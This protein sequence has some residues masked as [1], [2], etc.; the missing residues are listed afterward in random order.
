MSDRRL[1]AIDL[2]SRRVGWSY[3]RGAELLSVGAWEL[4]TKRTESPGFRWIRLRSYLD[5]VLEVSRLRIDVL[6]Y[7]EVRNHVSRGKGGRPS[8]NVSAAHAYGAAEGVLLAWADEKRL[9]YSSVTVQAVK[10]AATGLGGGKG[11]DKE[12][13]LAAARKRWPAQFSRLSDHAYEREP[14]YDE[15]DAAMIGLAMLIQLGDAA[16]TPPPPKA[17]KEPKPKAQKRAVKAPAT[18]TL[19]E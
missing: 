9:H 19:F 2:G 11:T 1:L 14:P 3:F 13:V 5:S 8:F 15:A 10:A 16:A 17:P 18:A 4:D 6:A 12:A 7:E